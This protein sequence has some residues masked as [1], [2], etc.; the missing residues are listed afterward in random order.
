ME[1]FFLRAKGKTP[2]ST[3][4]ARPSGYIRRIHACASRLTGERDIDFPSC[5]IFRSRDALHIDQ[6]PEPVSIPMS[7]RILAVGIAVLIGTAAGRDAANAAAGTCTRPGTNTLT[8]NCFGACTSSSSVAYPLCV[9]YAAQPAN[10]SSRVGDGN[11]YYQGCAFAGMSTCKANVSANNCELQCLQTSNG[12][13]EE[14]VLDV[15]QPQKDKAETSLFQYVESVVLPPTLKNLCV[16]VR[17]QHCAFCVEERGAD[18][19]VL[20]PMLQEHHWHDRVDPESAHCILGGCFRKQHR[21]GKNVR[22]KSNASCAA[23][24]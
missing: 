17:C 5:G 3:H 1:L 13:Q 2:Y 9:N 18:G 19:C 14:W 8:S 23:W 7:R 24:I 10:D 21:F 16:F 4:P 20:F 11:Y 6:Q 22:D 12:K 15:A